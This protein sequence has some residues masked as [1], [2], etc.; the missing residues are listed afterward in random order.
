[1]LTLQSGSVSKC[2]TT[3]SKSEYEQLDMWSF[4]QAILHTL[5]VREMDGCVVIRYVCVW[6]A[7]VS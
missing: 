5:L 3:W 2:F 1:M 4:A 7:P 6:Q